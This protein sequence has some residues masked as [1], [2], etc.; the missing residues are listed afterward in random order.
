MHAVSVNTREAY[1]ECLRQAHDHY[2]NFPVASRLV[3][4]RLRGPIA[5]IYSF[6]RRGDDLADEGDRPADERLTA[7]DDLAARLDAAAAGTPDTDPTFIALAHAI[8]AH[9][10]P[11][12]LFHD[13]LNAFRQDVTKSRYQDFGEVVQ[14]C[15]CSAN[16]VGRLLLHLSGEA[17]ERRLALSDAVCTSLQLI[18]F[19]QDLAQ[20]YHEMGR[21]YIPMDDMARFGV[22]EA[23][24]RDRVTDTPFRHL[25]QHQYR[26]ADQLM[27]SGAPL[28]GLL[29]GRIGLEIRLIIVAGA[30]VLWHLQR[31]QGDLF[32][33]PRLQ[34][35]DYLVI[36]RDALIPRHR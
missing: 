9:G 3:P 30:R 4:P 34:A 35:R 31:Q 21:I 20:D 19:Y 8:S 24:F 27:R 25:M 17:D 15:R 22:T 7:L 10:L 14:Y 11:T 2:E 33:R 12:A 16:P 1:R 5:A 18:N 29:R 26:R 13:L 28:G 36:L 32:S 23:H 6:A